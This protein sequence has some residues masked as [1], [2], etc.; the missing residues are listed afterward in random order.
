M[1]VTPAAMSF[2]TRFCVSSREMP[3]GC[4][5]PMSFPGI[6]QYELGNGKGAGTAPDPRAVASVIGPRRRACS[7][8]KRERGTRG[9]QLCET[10][11]TGVGKMRDLHIP[12]RRKNGLGPARE[13]TLPVGQH[14]LHGS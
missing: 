9:L 11:P 12:E 10:E 6:T 2:F 8:L 14:L 4:S 13:L 7:R 5:P 3:A 1:H